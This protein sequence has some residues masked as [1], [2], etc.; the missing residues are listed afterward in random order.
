MSMRKDPEYE[1]WEDRSDLAE[2]DLEESRAEV[3]D[4]DLDD[5]QERQ[6]READKYRDR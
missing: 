1:G 4:E 2:L 5:Y 6:E 3:A